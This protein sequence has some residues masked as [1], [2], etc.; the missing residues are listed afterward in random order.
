MVFQTLLKIAK[1]T[2]YFL[3]SFLNYNNCYG[4]FSRCIKW[5]KFCDNPELEEEFEKNPHCLRNFKICSDHFQ[6]KFYNCPQLW[7]SSSL[8]ASA[9]PS[10]SHLDDK[11]LN[12]SL[13]AVEGEMLKGRLKRPRFTDTCLN[14]TNQ[15]ERWSKLRKACKI[16][17]D[18]R[19]TKMVLDVYV[20]EI[21]SYLSFSSI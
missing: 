1:G 5:I 14:I 18:T 7:D 11:G 21:L 6:R 2:I 16:D 10:V 20:C 19:F 8:M 9:V 13:E 4:C 15:F 12:V 3:F 17:S